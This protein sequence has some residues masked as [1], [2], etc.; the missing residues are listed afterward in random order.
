[1]DA[2]NADAAL[3]ILET[4]DDVRLL[5]T[6]RGTFDPS[7]SPALATLQPQAPVPMA[8]RYPVAL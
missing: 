2:E 1:V 7:R 8:K 3:K 6:A 5:F 4:R